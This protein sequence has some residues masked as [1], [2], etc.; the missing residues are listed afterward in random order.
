MNFNY[1]KNMNMCC[2]NMRGFRKRNGSRVYIITF[3]YKHT[4]LEFS[5]EKKKSRKE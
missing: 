4:C 2:G 1:F 5:D 3:N